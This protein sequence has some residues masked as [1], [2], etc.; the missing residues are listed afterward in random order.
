MHTSKEPLV[1]AIAF[2]LPQFHPIKENDEWWGKGFTEWT[3]VTKARPLFRGHY[4]PHLPSDLGFY[5]LRLAETREAQADLARQYGIYGFCYYHYWFNGRRL[6]ERP[7]NDIL[8]SG[9]PNFP[10]C[11][12]WANENWTRKWDGG[13]NKTLILQEYSEE[14]D[15]A[16]MHWLLRTFSDPRYIRIG[17]KPLFLVYRSARLPNPKKTT[18]IWRREAIR[19]GIGELFLCLVESNFPDVRVIP[20][21]HGFDAAV[22][23]QPNGALFNAS[24]LTRVVRRISAGRSNSRIFKYED[25]V[26]KTLAEQPPPYCRYPCVAPSWDNS[27]RRRQGAFILKGSSPELYERWL[28]EVINNTSPS[29][30]NEKIVF[31]NA[32]NEWAEG[33]H[34]EPCQKWGRGY[35]E[36]TR[37][38][39]QK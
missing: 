10:F 20:T 28:R 37:R 36:A 5:D 27:A 3:N 19:A 7:V 1:R 21:D 17:G 2:H 4:Q 23:F 18:D 26:R 13:E 25:L 38:A 34:L 11:L 30:D 35:L 6:L 24:F 12:C 15:I 16:H 31:I 9:R 14:D 29:V 33:C 22:D 32:W 8:A 39:L